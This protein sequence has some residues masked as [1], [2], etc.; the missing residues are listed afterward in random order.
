MT[1]STSSRGKLY[2]SRH[3]RYLG[4][5]CGGLARYFGID[6][7]L[8]R[9][10]FVL[11]ALFS[12]VG[13][14][15]YLAALIVVPEDPDEPPVAPSQRSSGYLF[16]GILFL[17]FGALLLLRQFGVVDL[18]YYFHIPW[19][20]VWAILLI[21]IG[22]GLIYEHTRRK[23]EGDGD[24]AGSGA[25][26]PSP[27]SIGPGG[28]Q[29]YR[30][31]D[32]RK[33]F[34]VCGGLAMAFDIDPALVRLG[35]IL[36]TL[37]S[38]GLGIVVYVLFIFLFPEAPSGDG[39]SGGPSG[40]GQAPPSGSGGP[41]VTMKDVPAR[42]AGPPRGAPA[43]SASAQATGLEART[44]S[45]EAPADKEAEA[46]AAEGEKKPA[47]RKRRTSTK[48]SETT[49]KSA[50]TRKRTTRK[51]DESVAG[52]GE[53]EKKKPA[54]RTPRKSSTTRKKPDDRKSGGDD[55]EKP[56]ETA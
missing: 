51:S 9:L 32:D 45:A 48:A 54:R 52:E 10:L 12:G 4:G 22:A 44:P 16:W 15:V 6:A 11:A 53:G 30:T 18:F 26:G 21:L 33:L 3:E 17:A 5:V 20:M 38:G 35:W 41:L 8:V 50:T 43:P 40:G 37:A 27:M 24:D 31:V 1:D 28:R 13:I 25:G 2:R 55:T 23:S 19:R 7:N 42:P 34:G 56:D 49:R 36:L 29:I 14:F 47:P 39:A 46:E